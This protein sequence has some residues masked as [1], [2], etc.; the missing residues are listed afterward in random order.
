MGQQPDV[1]GTVTHK[2]RRGHDM[3]SLGHVIALRLAARMF[4]CSLN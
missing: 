3:N 2:A 1:V 4:R